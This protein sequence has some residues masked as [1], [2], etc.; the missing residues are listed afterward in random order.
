[1]MALIDIDEEYQRRKNL[2]LDINEHLE[3]LRELASRVN[4]VTEFGVRDGNSTVALAAAK[5]FSLVSY[6]IN[7]MPVDLEAAI[8]K[9]LSRFAFQ[10]IQANVLEVE[11]APTDF[12]FID[13]HH[14]Y[15]QLTKELKL[16]AGRVSKIIA[17]HDTETFGRTG[18]DGSTPGLWHA[19]EEFMAE[20]VFTRMDHYSNNNGLT[21]LWR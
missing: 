10:F 12:L 1:M 14:T 15:G 8:K 2:T 18:E 13:S 17:L 6:D 21:V 7:P 9:H 20:G 4:H 16:H 5:P 19:V 3:T 11:I